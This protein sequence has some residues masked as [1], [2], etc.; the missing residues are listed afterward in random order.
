MRSEGQQTRSAVSAE[1]QPLTSLVTG[2]GS[3]DRST[4]VKAKRNAIAFLRTGV[5]E[6]LDAARKEREA[7]KEARA[8]ARAESTGRGRKRPR[9]LPGQTFLSGQQSQLR[10]G[11]SHGA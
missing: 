10:A 1:L 9:Q 3:R 11:G 7:A 8:A 5:R 4:H 6:D 2:T